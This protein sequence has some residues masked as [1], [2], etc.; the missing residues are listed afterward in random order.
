M[1][2]KNYKTE[3]NGIN[4]TYEVNIQNAVVFSWKMDESCQGNFNRGVGNW[5][6]TLKP[7]WQASSDWESFFRVLFGC[8]IYVCFLK[9]YVFIYLS[10]I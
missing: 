5:N 1:Y 10:I 2:T 8:I 7:G 4:Y 9:V 6:W 3:K